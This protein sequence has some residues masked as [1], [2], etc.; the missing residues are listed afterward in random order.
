MVSVSIDADGVETRVIHDLVDFGGKTVIEVGC[1][2]GRLTWRYAP[3]A[4]EVVAVD[5]NENKIAAANDATPSD[6]RGKVTF[7]AVDIIDLDAPDESFDVAILSY[8][9]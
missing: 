2:D 8:A 6:L 9:L 1:G 7:K 5:V 4:A 3:A